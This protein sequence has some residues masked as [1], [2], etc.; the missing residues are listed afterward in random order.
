MQCDCP[1]RAARSD[2]LAKQLAANTYIFHQP[3]PQSFHITEVTINRPSSNLNYF[4]V[5]KQIGDSNDPSNNCNTHK[6]IT[7]FV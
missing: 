1:F 5:W 2:R 7:P 3:L 4:S 6:G